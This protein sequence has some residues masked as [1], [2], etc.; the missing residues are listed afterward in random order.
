MIVSDNLE[1]WRLMEKL[2]GGEG[3]SKACGKLGIDV[4]VGS[5]MLRTLEAERGEKLFDRTMRPMKLTAAAERLM[6]SV[7]ALLAA[8]RHLLV[9]SRQ[10]AGERTFRL[11][12]PV[13]IARTEILKCVSLIEADDAK[14]HI[15]I[16]SEADQ[17]DLFLERADI[18]LLPYVPSDPRVMSWSICETCTVG[19]ASLGYIEACGNPSSPQELKNHRLLLRAG[20]H[21]PTI[22]HLEN[23]ELRCPIP[24][25]SVA[26]QGDI[27]S[28]L[29]LLLDGR[30]ICFDLSLGLAIQHILDGRLQPVLPDWHRPKWRLALAILAENYADEPLTGLSRT[31]S[32]MLRKPLSTR[33]FA[34][35]KRIGQAFPE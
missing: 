13:N 24:T 19:L 12:I 7:T 30:G 23:G 28:C 9:H 25:E 16:V 29:E 10:L 5:R 6:P 33:T 35:Y 20:G 22:T 11:G 14:T 17:D 1:V 27:A 2:A 31:L 4:S 21:Y 34:W 3:L 18:V 15:E 26:F 8:H 32:R